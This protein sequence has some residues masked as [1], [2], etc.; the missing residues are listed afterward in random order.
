MRKIPGTRPPELP[1]LVRAQDRISFVYLERC[2]VH[3]QDNAITAT[4]ERGTVHLPAATLG[5]LLLGPGTRVSHQAMVLLAESGSTAVWVGERGVRY[6]AHGRSLARSSRLLEAQAA[7]VSNQQRR[8][9]VARAMYA[10]RFPGE[11]VEGQT[12]QQLRGRE[13]ARV[14]R[15]YRSMSAETG[16]VWD[17]RDYNSEDFASGTLIN[18]ALSAAHT[19]L[20]GIV[21]AVIVALGCSPGLGVVHTGHVRSFVFDIADLYKAEISI[22]VAFR[23]AAT[24]PEDVGAETRRAVRDAVHDGKILA[25]C[26][27]DIRQLLL[28]D[29]DPVE[30]DVDADVINLW[31]GDDRVVSGG[32]GY[33]ESDTW[34]F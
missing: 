21:H 7:I 6:Y 18:Q 12:M 4:D 30:D 3:R 24:E 10:M 29:Q 19:C 15:V 17:K 28:P 1:E 2:I 22:P 16:V 11:D 25:R 34:S 8:L 5:A 13:G 9:A 33:V 27:R 23:V 31:D 32:T 26:A 20:Y 14:R